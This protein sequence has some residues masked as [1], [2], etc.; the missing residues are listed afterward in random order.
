MGVSP[1]CTLDLDKV[2]MPPIW[3]QQVKEDYINTYGVMPSYIGKALEET[4]KRR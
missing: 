4:N 3:G 2:A 1:L